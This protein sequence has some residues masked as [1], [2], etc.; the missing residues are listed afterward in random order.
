M[1][2][3]AA[4]MPPAGCD[5]AWQ[6]Q[7]KTKTRHNLDTYF[8]YLSRK[9]E[10]TRASA[11]WRFD[12]GSA[13]HATARSSVARVSTA[14]ALFLVL[15]MTA[16][17]SNTVVTDGNGGQQSETSATTAL[18]GGT[19]RIVVAF[20]DDTG[21]QN[22]LTYTPTD[23]VI[24]EGVSLMGWSYSDNAGASWT[25]GGKVKP[26][27]NWAVL[28]GDPAIGTSKTQY[29]VV[30]MANLAIP[31]SKFPAGGIH[32]SVDPNF[33]ESYIGGACI[34]KS[35]DA[36]KSFKIYQCVSNT[37][38]V[39]SVADSSL[40]H[41]YDGGSVVGSNTGEIFAAWVD[42]DTNQ[43]DVYRSPNE[44]G[45]F[46]LIAT[47]FPGMYAG[48]HPRLRTAPDG[49]LYVGTHVSGN[50]GNTYVYLNRYSNGSWGTPIKA[51]LPAIYYPSI[52]LGTTLLGSEL[53]LRAGNQFSFDIGAASADGSD[54]IRLLYV[55][56]DPNTQKLFIDASACRLDLS[57]C[58]HVPGWAT[59]GDNGPAS[60]NKL[61]DYYNPEVAAWPGFIGLPPTWQASWGYHFNGATG[62]YVSRLTLGYVNGT[63]FYIPVDIIKNA[64]VCSDQRGYW[65]DYDSM[66]QIGWQ[67]GSSVWMRFL[68]DSS[69]GCSVR[70]QYTGQ[71]Q[72][73]QQANYAY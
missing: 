36:G 29:N 30:F 18:D 46:A 7:K 20:N 6:E 44:N 13:V 71:G 69:Q 16:C 67:N 60:G 62:V 45:T 12:G 59:Q 17:S 73:V 37:D 64:P 56:Q 47:P 33:P 24:N 50:D 55:R 54:A 66:L 65:G 58:A 23:R 51:G 72:R 11:S 21:N 35:T 22:L 26:P 4:K 27:Q 61:I 10:A 34:A 5:A 38:P 31:T 15:L 53:T 63:A 19:T 48:S 25:Y 2:K 49:S 39:P 8:R 9:V 43:I 68:T 1:H 52:D 57:A 28:W 3:C 14:S 40:G 42:Y 41:F 32:G 70:W